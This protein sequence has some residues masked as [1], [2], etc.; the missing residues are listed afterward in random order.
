MNGAGRDSVFG[1]RAGW[2]RLAIVML[3][4]LS[5]LARVEAE[6]ADSFDITAPGQRLAAPLFTLPDLAANRVSL[7]DFRGK[8][9]L[10]HFWAT[11][12]I[13]CLHELPGLEGLW[14]D[15]REQGLVILA[16]AADRGSA[17]VVRDFSDRHGLSFPVLHDAEG[18][19]RNRYEV[20][21][22]P[23][24]YIIG[25]D[26]KI[27]GRAIGSREWNSVAGRRFVERLL[28]TGAT[29]RSAP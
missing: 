13:P 14:R 27:S 2:H 18:Q 8:V 19:V 11:F 12:C 21:A 3:A 17:A 20:A 16:V 29:P 9:V 6:P 4:G 23:T 10:V 25:R 1:W 7:E 24:S 15:F 28:D 5:L 26:G 22:L